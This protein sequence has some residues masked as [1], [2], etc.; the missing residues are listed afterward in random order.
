M[1]M[2]QKSIS[3]VNLHKKFDHLFKYEPDLSFHYASQFTKW[4]AYLLGLAIDILWSMQPTCFVAVVIVY[5]VPIAIFEAGLRPGQLWCQ[6]FYNGISNGCQMV[7]DYFCIFCRKFSWKRAHI[8]E[9]WNCHDERTVCQVW[10]PLL[11]FTSLN[12]ASLVW[13]HF[14]EFCSLIGCEFRPMF[15]IFCKVW[16]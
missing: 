9:G 15:S 3:N 4:F 7:A 14:G 1:C 8:C 10:H 12:Q 13:K 16:T 5:L 6:I 11:F 2:V